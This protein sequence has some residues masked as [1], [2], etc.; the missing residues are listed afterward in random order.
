[1]VITATDALTGAKTYYRSKD[2]LGEKGNLFADS[3]RILKT[4]KSFPKHS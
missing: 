3:E 2:G 1:M 4:Y